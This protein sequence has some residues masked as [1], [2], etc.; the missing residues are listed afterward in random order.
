MPTNKELQLMEDMWHNL[1]YARVD[2]LEEVR[3][4]FLKCSAH[5]LVY[6]TQFA[7]F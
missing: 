1:F 5:Y 2:Q 6:E 4:R 7:C 3:T